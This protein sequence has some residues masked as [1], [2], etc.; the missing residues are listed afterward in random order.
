MWYN[1]DVPRERNRKEMIIM[2]KNRET[3]E[4]ISGY[5]YNTRMAR[6][7]ADCI[8]N[9]SAFNE[10]VDL[11][12][13]CGHASEND[14]DLFSKWVECCRNHVAVFMATKWAPVEVC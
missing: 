9:L 13:Y 1:I 2:F 10:W 7:V 11:M 12:E 6:E 8:K 4:V 14:L 3:G 5:D